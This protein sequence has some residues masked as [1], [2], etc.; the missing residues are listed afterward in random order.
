M[1]RFARYVLPL[2]ALTAATPAFAQDWRIAAISGAKP[3]RSVYLVDQAATVRNGSA[4]T[5]TTQSIFEKLTEGR[6]FDRS[7]TR[8]FGDCTTMSSAIIENTYYANGYLKSKDKT[9]GNTIAHREGTVM[10]G[11]LAKACGQKPFEG[12]MLVNPETAVR[13]YFAKP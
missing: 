13:A 4:I 1:I 8:R 10:Y 7:V 9:K 11:V 5:L 6:D 3:D 12:N 2:L